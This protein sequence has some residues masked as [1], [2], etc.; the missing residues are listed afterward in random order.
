VTAKT[1][2][3]TFISPIE[4]TVVVVPARR[5][6]YTDQAGNVIDTEDIPGKRA[7]FKG[8][9]VTTDDPQ[10]IEYLRN[11][12]RYGTERGWVEDFDASRPNRRERARQIAKLAARADT[13]GLRELIAE[14]QASGDGGRD[15][16]LEQARIALEQL[17]EQAALL[18]DIADTE[19]GSEDAGEGEPPEGGST[20]ENGEA[21]PGGPPDG[22][23]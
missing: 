15:D 22:G 12:P 9:K 7:V 2:K 8:R 19:P 11:H 14:E 21:D 1:Q 17:E 6:H 5:R 18:E 4:Q 3:V 20:D 23:D 10:I 16:V 13:D